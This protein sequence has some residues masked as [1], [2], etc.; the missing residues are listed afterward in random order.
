MCSAGNAGAG[1]AHREMPALLVRPPADLHAAVGRRVLGG[2]VDE[3]GERRL[4]HGLVADELGCGL[5]DDFD[6]PRMRGAREHVLAK[7]ATPSP[8][9]RWAAP[10]IGASLA[11]KRDSS[12]RSSMMRVMRSVWRRISATGAASSPSPGSALKF[13]RYPATTVSGERSSCDALATK[14]L[15]ICSMRTS[16]VTSRSMSRRWSSPYEMSWNAM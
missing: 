11:S 1:V 15:R 13:S 2:V 8:T 10:L 12:S 4:H 5:D 3:V 16:R 9:H 7:H 14:S 6:L